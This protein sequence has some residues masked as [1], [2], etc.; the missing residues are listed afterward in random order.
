MRKKKPSFEER[1]KELGERFLQ[2]SPEQRRKVARQVARMAGMT[3]GEAGREL[4]KQMR[5]RGK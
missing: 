5:K 4:C 3:V 2:M 1:F